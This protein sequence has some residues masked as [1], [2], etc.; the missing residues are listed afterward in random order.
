MSATFQSVINFLV[1]KY[2]DTTSTK[3]HWKKWLK[4]A[5]V[6]HLRIVNWPDEVTAPGPS[7]NLKKIST[8]ALSLLVGGYLSNQKNNNEEY[9]VPEIERWTR[10]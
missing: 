4:T 3:M 6:H 2:C 10:G 5:M 8:P 7:F 1:E 9:F